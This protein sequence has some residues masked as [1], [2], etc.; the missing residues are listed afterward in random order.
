MGIVRVNVATGEMNPVNTFQ[1]CTP[2]W[3]PDSRRVIFSCRPPGQPGGGGYG[4]T[5]LWMADGEGKKS[6][7]VYGEDL[8][9]IY[10]GALS[11]DAK[12]VLFSRGIEDGAGSESSGAPLCVMRL[13]DA[14][15][16]AGK[17]QDL[18]KVHPRT[19]DGPVLEL[20]EGWEPCW[21]YA[22]IGAAK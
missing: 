22:E 20:A 11:P 9:H 4:W 21:T 16:I 5:Q 3:F 15:T 12:Y 18:R 7:L 19:K 14:P 8:R 1:S 2:D 13:S 6:G 17:S 10:G